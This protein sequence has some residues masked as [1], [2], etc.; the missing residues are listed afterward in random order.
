M[1]DNIWLKFMCAG[2]RRPSSMLRNL[3]FSMSDGVLILEF[4]ISSMSPALQ[5]ETN[6]AITPF[7]KYSSDSFPFEPNLWETVSLLLPK[8]HAT[9]C[10][11]F[12]LS[13]IQEHDEGINLRGDVKK[14]FQKVAKANPQN[15]ERDL[16]RIFR[17]LGLSLPLPISHVVL[18]GK[19]V[20]YLSL[21]SWW[22]LLL[23][24]HSGLVLGGFDRNDTCSKLLLNSFWNN[25]KVQFNDHAVFDMHEAQGNLSKCI[26][27]FL[28]IDEG[29]GLRRSAVLV[30]SMQTIFGRH[31]AKRF[32]YLHSHS[33][34]HSQSDMEKR[35]TLAQYHNA[36]GSTYL[37]R[38]LF[39][40]LPKKV[41]SQKNSQVY[42]GVLETL[43]SECIELMENGV[44]I[45]D[46][47]YYPVCLG[48]KGDQPALIKSGAFKRSFM[49]LGVDRGC[50][51]ECLAGFADYPFEDC[52]P[53]PKWGATVGLAV[54]W[55]E[56]NESPLLQIAGQSSLPHGFWKRDPF[57]AFKQTLGG[58]FGASTIILFAIDFGLWKIEGLSNDVDSLLERAFQDFR[59]FVQHE[60]RGTVINHTQAFTRITLHF[61]SYDKFPFARWKGSDQMLIIRWLRNLVLNGI[62]FTGS[63]ERDGKSLLHFPPQAWQV[64][65]F[66]AV[67][68]GSTSSLCFFRTLHNE[69]VWL[70]QQDTFNMSTNCKMFCTSFATLAT[71]SHQRKLARYHLE[72]CLH[73]FRHFAYDLD[74]ALQEG[75]VSTLSPSVVTC[76]MDED[77]V[78]KICR[79]SRHVHAKTTNLRTIERYLLRCHAEFEKA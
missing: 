12:A 52:G 62:F 70:D 50:C 55:K 51:W 79:A 63:V 53:D 18:H 27:Y 15:A 45:N 65:F 6:W 23:K 29:V 44:N 7:G 78:G 58:H 31:T 16:H 34:G 13:T 35:M 49:N 77:F 72:P 21:K 43:A 5:H 46:V 40:A 67:L 76:E 73:T 20:H 30:V 60:W 14:M 56:G 33:G 47:K 48:I 42:W 39:T 64:P 37:T 26:P 8:V 17:K 69:G 59:F 28:H 71:L 11:D 57:H 3:A 75:C 61:G 32:D 74:Q 1:H 10:R 54:P 36:H 66:R 24:N 2:Q 9:K 19:P 68:D 22:P 41:Y 25:Y 4:S 38:F